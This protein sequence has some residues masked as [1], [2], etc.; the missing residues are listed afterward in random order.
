MTSMESTAFKIYYLF[1]ET[2]SKVFPSMKPFPLGTGDPRKKY[3]FKVCYKLVRETTNR[4]NYKDYPLYIRAQFDIIKINTKKYGKE[5]NIS[6]SCLIGEKAWNRWLVWKKMYEKRQDVAVTINLEDTN[7]NDQHTIEKIKQSLL[8]DK[9]F[10]LTKVKKLD[11]ST[12][13]SMVNSRVLLRWIAIG[14]I[15]PYYALMSPILANWIKRNGL[16]LQ[17]ML[18]FDYML[19]KQSISPESEELFK[20]IFCHEFQ[21]NN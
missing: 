11:F 8:R 9:A 16:D 10:L 5:P 12:C 14:Q 13:E 19:Y 2:A 15:S 21:A 17:S 7:I 6:P 3:L 4:I 1:I 18:N 20:V